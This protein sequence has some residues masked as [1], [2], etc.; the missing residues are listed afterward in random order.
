MTGSIHNGSGFKHNSIVSIYW[1][2]LYYFCHY[3]AF[4]YIKEI[5][6]YKKCVESNNGSHGITGMTQDNS[7]QSAAPRRVVM[8]S[9]I[10]AVTF[11]ITGGVFEG[12]FRSGC[13]LLHM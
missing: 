10:T 5:N 6:H 1:K 4:S 2:I 8:V 12:L 3:A 13:L 9:M 11:E 7:N